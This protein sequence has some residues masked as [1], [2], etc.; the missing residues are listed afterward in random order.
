MKKGGEGLED[1]MEEW[2]K[3]RIR[4]RW[5]GTYRNVQMEEECY[6]KVNKD[7]RECD[8]NFRT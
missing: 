6:E 5:D 8:T 7:K 4:R 1:E 2:I 3:E